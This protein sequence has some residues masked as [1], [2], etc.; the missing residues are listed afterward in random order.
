MVG[1]Q[2]SVAAARQ[3]HPGL[4]PLDAVLRS[5][6]Q[7]SDVEASIST[8]HVECCGGPSTE[9]GSLTSAVEM[10]A[11]PALAAL[12]LG[13]ILHAPR[14]NKAAQ[15]GFF[16]LGFFGI[17]PS[18]EWV[19]LLTLNRNRVVDD[20]ASH[21]TRLYGRNRLC[22]NSVNRPLTAF[23]RTVRLPTGCAPI[24]RDGLPP[25]SRSGGAERCLKATG[26]KGGDGRTA[27][28]THAIRQVARGSPRKKAS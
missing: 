9:R 16:I 6:L 20:A 12:L 11:A 28:P 5:K 27:I 19:L 17:R 13:L 18:L 10:D 15:P 7:C 24:P 25:R 23:D 21:M 2:V 3:Q 8:R 26:W 4:A 22:A 1:A 14:F